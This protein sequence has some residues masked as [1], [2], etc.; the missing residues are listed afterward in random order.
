M[1]G[2]RLAFLLVLSGL[3]LAILVTLGTWQLQRREWKN[4][5]IA[6]LE[7]SIAAE[8]VPW[9]PPD[10]EGGQR[11]FRKV[12]AEGRFL[13]EQAAYVLTPARGRPSEKGGFGYLVFTPLETDRGTVVVNR[14]YAPGQDVLRQTAQHDRA[15]VTGIIRTPE[16]GGLFAP[17]PQ[18]DRRLFFAPD[19]PAM[20]QALGWAA[21]GN[22]VTGEYIEADD[23]STADEWPSGRDPRELLAAI[24]NRHLEYALTW[25]G[26]ALT[27]V[28]VTFAYVVRALRTGGPSGRPEV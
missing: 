17:D 7:R 8:P 11:Q 21:R 13:H 18:P 15:V 2:R 4:A 28:A 6:D 22:L 5:L 12:R 24:P 27:L 3:A 9:T 16:D 19:V 1:Q 23:R 25:Y 26:L 20:A 14:G 10:M